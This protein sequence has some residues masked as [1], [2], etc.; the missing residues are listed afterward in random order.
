MTAY[1]EGTLGW[2][3]AH[4]A[5]E[6]AELDSPLLEAD[7]LLAHFADKDRSWIHVHAND[8]VPKELNRA[9]LAA[10]VRRK[11]REPLQY[12]TGECDFDGLPVIV[13]PGCLVPRPETELLVERAARVFDGTVFLDWGTGTGCRDRSRFCSESRCRYSSSGSMLGL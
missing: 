12:I 8:P 10:C 1:K 13:G 11:M 9:A 6:L 5:A 3:R 7:L 4:I 2:L